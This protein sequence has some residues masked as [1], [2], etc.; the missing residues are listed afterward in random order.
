MKKEAYFFSHDSNARHDPK[1]IMLRAEYGYQGYG[2]FWAIVEMMR[3]EPGYKLNIKS[4]YGLSAIAEE[5]HIDK[6][7]CAKFLNSCVKDFE[8][9]SYDDEGFLYSK[10]LQK[11]MEHWDR[12]KEIYAEKGK[13]G[14]EIR[15]RKGANETSNEY[16][17]PIF[18]KK[19]TPIEIDSTPIE[20][21]STPIE[22]NNT[23]IENDNPAN[24]NDNKQNKINNDKNNKEKENILENKR[25]E[26]I[27][28]NVNSSSDMED[29]IK[30]ANYFRTLLPENTYISESTLTIWANVYR[31][32]VR[33]ELKTPEEIYAVCKWARENSFWKDKFLNPIQ[34]TQKIDEIEHI[35]IFLNQM[36]RENGKK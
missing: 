34:L 22:I 4:K 5:L 2:W 10:S 9:F 21:D 3:E 14:A 13:K 15:W 36:K 7:T 27:K 23:T 24:K 25:T 8:L 20:I 17:N 35:D 11:R 33:I 1:I 31:L 16:I 6:D 18:F 30:F 28:A 19:C 32:L 29:G 26:I 12:Q